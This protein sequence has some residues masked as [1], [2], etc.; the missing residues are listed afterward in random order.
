M[1]ESSPFRLAT[2][3]RASAAK[4]SDKKEEHSTFKA[5]QMPNY[6][7]FEPKTGEKKQI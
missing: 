2:A 5:K 3:E 1:T 7:F 6:E 4:P